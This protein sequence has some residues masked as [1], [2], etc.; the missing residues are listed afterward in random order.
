MSIRYHRRWYWKLMAVS[1]LASFSAG[2]I[3]IHGHYVQ[4][5]GLALTGLMLAFAAGHHAHV[6]REMS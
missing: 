2:W 4:G 3:A 5:I 1:Y 6:I